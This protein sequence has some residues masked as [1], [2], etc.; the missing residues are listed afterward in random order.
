MQFVTVL[1]LALLVSS[2]SILAPQ[3]EKAVKVVA[4][5]VDAACAEALPS[6]RQRSIDMINTETKPGN[7]LIIECADGQK[8]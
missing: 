7:K 5:I 4:K 1:L 3:E 2:C 6:I 8:D